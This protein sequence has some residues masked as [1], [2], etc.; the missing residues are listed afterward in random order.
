MN[1][2]KSV[3]NMSL[4]ISKSMLSMSML[5]E[6]IRMSLGMSERGL[7]RPGLSERSSDEC[8]GSGWP[9]LHEPQYEH[10]HEHVEQEHQHVEHEHQDERGNVSERVD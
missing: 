7:T 6:S 3:S 8:M 10:E 2:S 4:S 1:I 5:S 9:S